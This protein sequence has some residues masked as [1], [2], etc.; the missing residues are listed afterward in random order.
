MNLIITF[1]FI[2]LGKFHC[3]LQQLIIITYACFVVVF[4]LP[5]N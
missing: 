4:L 5:T 2:N 1:P 3:L